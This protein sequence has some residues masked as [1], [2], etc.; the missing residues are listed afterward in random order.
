MKYLLDTNICVHL[1]RGKYHLDTKLE[2]VGIKS[3]AISEITYV[4]LVYGAEKSS[5]PDKNYE[6]IE[7][8][9]SQLTVLPI[10]DSIRLYAKEK[11]SLQ[12]QGMMISDF[13]LL[14]G[15]TALENALIMVTE[16]IR[17]FERISD[18]HLA[19]WIDRK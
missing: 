17:E 8:F 18:I 5:N 15:C 6:L 4:E 12:R 9:V 13:D 3:C 10:F 11:A 1:L 16:N 14:I 7:R 19:N 2:T